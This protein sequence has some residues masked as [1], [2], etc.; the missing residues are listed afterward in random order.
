MFSNQNERSSPRSPGWNSCLLWCPRLVYLISRPPWNAFPSRPIIEKKAVSV[1]M[2]WGSIY[3]YPLSL[4]FRLSGPGFL[5]KSRPKTKMDGWFKPNLWKQVFAFDIKTWSARCQPPLHQPLRPSTHNWW[6]RIP[7]H[8]T[9][10]CIGGRQN[11]K[12]SHCSHD[13]AS[14][15]LTDDLK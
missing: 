9:P 13:C 10:A 7:R 14:I 8:L 2:T 3:T 15:I 12:Y 1:T 5:K 6:N 11:F 4:W